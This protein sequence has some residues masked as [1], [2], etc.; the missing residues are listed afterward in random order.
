MA[1]PKRH[2]RVPGTYFVTSQTWERRALFL[3]PLACDIFVQALL[4]YR[5]Q[6][7]Y[8]L[9]AFVLMPDHFHVLL[10][11]APPRTLERVMQLIKGGSAHRMGK[12]LSFPFPVWHRGFSD[13]RIRDWRDYETHLHHIELNPV[14]R[15]LADAPAAYCWSS[16]CG[17]FALDEVP[18]GLKP[19]EY[20]GEQRHG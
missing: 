4:H 18:Q 17:A 11:P 14:K 13:H 15:K 3:K 6:A 20:V 8:Q 7:N 12:E 9:L 2:G 19:L 16:A 10:T 1:I 5:A